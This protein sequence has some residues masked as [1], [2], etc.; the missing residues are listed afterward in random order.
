M[1]WRQAVAGARWLACKAYMRAANTVYRCCCIVRTEVV[2][3]TASPV[4][5][6]TFRAFALT[7]KSGD[8]LYV[9]LWDYDVGH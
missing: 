4:F 8:K 3:D 2:R 5:G 9:E 7:P 1:R 6:L